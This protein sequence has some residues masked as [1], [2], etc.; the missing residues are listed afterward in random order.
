M[1]FHALSF[2]PFP[3][4]FFF[5]TLFLHP[6]AIPAVTPH[7]LTGRQSFWSSLTAVLCG[8]RTKAWCPSRT[9]CTPTAPTP[10]SFAPTATS[11]RHQWPTDRSAGRYHTQNTGELSSSSSRSPSH[12]SLPLSPPLPLPLSPSPFSCLHFPPFPSLSL[13]FPPFPSLPPSLPQGNTLSQ[14]VV[15]VVLSEIH[16]IKIGAIF[17]IFR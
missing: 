11:L 9:P 7:R 2:P 5:L 17:Y 6:S 3:I 8:C 4:A 15:A 1:K 10:V 14:W 16:K 13:P 12:S